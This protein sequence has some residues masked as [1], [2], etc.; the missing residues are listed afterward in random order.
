MTRP[1]LNLACRHHIPELILES[2]ITCS[3]GPTNQPEHNLFTEFRGQWDHIDQSNYKTALEDPGTLKALGST[4]QNAI[5]FCPPQTVLDIPH[6]FISHHLSKWDENESF[7][8]CRKV[9]KSLRVTNDYAERGVALITKH[10]RRITNKEEQ[11]QYLLQVVQQ[12]R[13]KYSSAAKKSFVPLWPLSASPLP[14]PEA[15]TPT[16][17]VIKTIRLGDDERSR[18]SVRV[19]A[20]GRLLAAATTLLPRKSDKQRRDSAKPLIFEMAANSK[21][22]WP[23]GL[24]CQFFL[25]LDTLKYIPANFMFMASPSLLPA[26]RLAV[27]EYMFLTHNPRASLRAAGGRAMQSLSRSAARGARP[28]LDFPPI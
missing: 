6:E 17:T 11:Q 9:V 1:L 18:V 5:T 3:I 20:S 21:V 19:R 27:Y 7:Q 25:I 15:R 16:L 10:N 28:R 23:T 13:A 26:L 24:K 8:Q 4:R 14:I 12:H 22:Q 2:A